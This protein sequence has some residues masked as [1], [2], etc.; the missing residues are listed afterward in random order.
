MGDEFTWEMVRDIALGNNFGDIGETPVPTPR[1]QTDTA[2]SR[3]YGLLGFLEIYGKS[4]K[5]GYLEMARRIGDNTLLN[6]FHKGF[7]IPSH[8]S[9]KN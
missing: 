6:Q 9:H 8:T 3:V 2:Y 7:F 4:K 1:L 5:P